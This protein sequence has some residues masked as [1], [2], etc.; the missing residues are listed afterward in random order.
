MI[1]IEEAADKLPGVNEPWPFYR[2]TFFRRSETI[3]P[4][5]HIGWSDFLQNV[6]IKD[7]AHLAYRPGIP[8]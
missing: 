7:I 2:T 4:D 3:E 1:R 8:A 6:D 5:G